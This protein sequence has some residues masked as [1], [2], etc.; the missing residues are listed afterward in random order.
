MHLGLR[1]RRFAVI[2]LQMMILV[3]S[4]DDRDVAINV[5]QI[6]SMASPGGLVTDKS[7]CLIHFN[8]GHF[9]NTRETC[10]VVG[11]LWRVED[12]KVK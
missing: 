12:A 6:T 7:G 2:M 4:V 9:L 1:V 10:D 11:E 8:N 3:H 5:E